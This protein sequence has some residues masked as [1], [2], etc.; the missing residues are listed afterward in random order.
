MSASEA[1]LGDT[2]V[3]NTVFTT[4]DC[5]GIDL[6]GCKPIGRVGPES[7]GTPQQGSP[8]NVSL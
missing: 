8:R 1:N 2:D 5:N 6:I 7:G 4:L 3:S